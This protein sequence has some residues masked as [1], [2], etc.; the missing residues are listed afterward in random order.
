MAFITSNSQF[1]NQE[2]HVKPDTPHTRYYI[3]LHQVLRLYEAIALTDLIS[4]FPEHTLYGKE[5][6]KWPIREVQPHAFAQLFTNSFLITVQKRVF[7]SFWTL[8]YQ[9]QEYIIMAIVK[10]QQS[11]F[12]FAVLHH[13]VNSLWPSD[14]V[15]HHGSGS[16]LAQI[17]TCWL[18]APSHYL[19][20]CWIIINQVLWHSPKTIFTGS[21]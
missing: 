21:T 8:L 12:L 19:N 15:W 13:M 11:S 2:F 10:Q 6:W 20:Q 7:C 16:K 9:T 5:R 14:I 3:G 4:S 17:M 18:T 1:H